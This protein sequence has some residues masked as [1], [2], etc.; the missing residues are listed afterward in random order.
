MKKLILAAFVLIVSYS[1]FAQTAT[2]FT[3]NDCQGASHNLFSE[4]N[5]GKV[6]IL[7]WVMPCGACAGPSTTAYNLATG[8]NMTQ[9]GRVFLYMIDDY[10]NTSCLTLNGWANSILVP[11]NSYSLRFSNPAIDMLDYGTVGMPKVVVVG[12]TN[13][14]VFY[15]ANNT[16]NAQAMQN[17]IDAAL[18]ATGIDE[19]TTLLSELTVFPNP[20]DQAAE[21][22]FSM[23]K[24]EE[25]KIEL[26]NL[27]GKKL[28]DVYSGELLA[29]ESR[30][31]VKT[32]RLAAA[33]YLVKV[34]GGGK[35]RFI[36]LM[37][38]H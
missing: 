37:V 8:Y 22:V 2:D 25:V 24:K 14:T 33:M 1:G 23:M 35:S 34:S 27:E 3:C 17:A 5:A 16:V 12:G 10:A 18:L 9:P 38:S 28:Q 31:S 21:I 26:F 6:I 20:A 15:N 19:Q 7:D 13:H 32:G 30:V 11:Q 36:N 4:L 29:G